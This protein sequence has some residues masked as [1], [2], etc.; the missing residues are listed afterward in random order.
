M[1]DDID[2]ATNP[3]LSKVRCSIASQWAR[4]LHEAES[5]G[6]SHPSIQARVDHLESTIEAFALEHGQVMAFAPSPDVSIQ[7]SPTQLTPA[8]SCESPP[9]S[10]SP[11]Q[12][13]IDHMF[14]F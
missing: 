3:A 6:S 4:V 10:E 7:L 13:G 2:E 14:K 1:D 11:G 12:Q 8:S 9:S 5:L